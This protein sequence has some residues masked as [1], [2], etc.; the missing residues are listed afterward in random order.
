MEKNINNSLFKKI[1]SHDS[2]FLEKIVWSSAHS[3]GI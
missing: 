1:T 2:E 3:K